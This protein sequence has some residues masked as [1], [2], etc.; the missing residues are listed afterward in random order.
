MIVLR[1]PDSHDALK[2][3]TQF[4]QYGRKAC[5]LVSFAGQDHHRFLIKDYLQ[6]KVQL[7]DRLKDGGLVGPHSCHNTLSHGKWNSLLP[8]IGHEGRGGSWAQES[9]LMGCWIVKHRAVLGYDPVEEMEA[10]K[11]V[12]Q[13]GK[14]ASRDQDHLS[15]RLPHSFQPSQSGTVDPTIAGQSPVVIRG[16]RPKS[17][18]PS[19]RYHHKC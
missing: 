8:Q 1:I 14:F 15:S 13:A 3:K 10:R 2:L 16:Y 4:R 5:A 17:H 7:P 12:T 11:H 18:R 19:R 9:F 6:V